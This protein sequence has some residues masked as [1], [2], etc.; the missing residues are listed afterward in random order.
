MFNACASQ[1]SG[2]RT[3]VIGAGRPEPLGAGS[4]MNAMNAPPP[5]PDCLT[6]RNSGRTA[7]GWSTSHSLRIGSAR[8]R[9]RVALARRSERRSALR[10]AVLSA[11]LQMISKSRGV[12]AEQA[13]HALV[14]RPSGLSL[15]RA[16]PRL[17]SSLSVT[18]SKHPKSK[19]TT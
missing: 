19:K 10:R 18:G 14:Y 7:T 6:R 5:P 11:G 2:R 3:R 13:L 4:P 15:N 12:A 8:N 1:L 9:T 16:R 17:K